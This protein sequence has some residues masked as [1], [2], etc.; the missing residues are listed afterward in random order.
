M[1]IGRFVGETCD[2]NSHRMYHVRPEVLRTAAVSQ[3]PVRGYWI[4][5][6]YCYSNGR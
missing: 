2:A 6:F 3:W 4:F 5:D 1:T